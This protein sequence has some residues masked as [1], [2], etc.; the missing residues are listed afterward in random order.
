MRKCHSKYLL[1]SDPQSSIPIFVSQITNGT[2][3]FCVLLNMAPEWF[4]RDFYTSC[5]SLLVL[6]FCKLY[7]FGH[8]VSDFTIVFIIFLATTKSE[9]FPCLIFLFHLPNTI[10]VHPLR[11]L[12]IF[13]SRPQRYKVI[14]TILI[15]FQ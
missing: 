7:C 4:R 9:S 12:K 14:Y 15:F 8:T 1:F 10:M 13:T 2:L 11:F 3:P 5:Q 6:L